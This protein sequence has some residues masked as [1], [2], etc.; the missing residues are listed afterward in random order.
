M[1]RHFYFR[2]CDILDSAGLV[3]SDAVD[4]A[5]L[6]SAAERAGIWEG[7]ATYLAIVSDYVEQYRGSGINL[8]HFVRASARFGGG[9][10][11]Y[12]KNF[13]RVPIMPQSAGLYGL[14]L[15]GLLKKRELHSTAR[16]GLLPWLATAAMVG[17]KIT[18][19]D[20]GIW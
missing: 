20:K 18:G 4:Y 8:P 10:V 6:R 5:D 13:L 7:V 19:S 16:L 3:E 9:E 12:R 14:Q 17:Q 15:T 1:Y 11:F 2:L